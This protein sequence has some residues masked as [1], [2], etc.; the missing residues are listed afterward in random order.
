M[1]V[2]LAALPPIARAAE[3]DWGFIKFAEVRAYRMNWDKENAFNSILREGGGLNET[4]LPKEGVTLNEKQIAALKAAVTGPQK[5]SGVGLG[6]FFPHHAFVFY[7]KGGA[8]T[9]HIDVCFLCSACGVEPAGF[10]NECDLKALA[11]LIQDLGLP[12]SNP[13]WPSKRE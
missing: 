1:M 13:A 5:N 11:K 2:T 12:L 8:S 7:D 4:R 6:C 9:G 3:Q 10:T